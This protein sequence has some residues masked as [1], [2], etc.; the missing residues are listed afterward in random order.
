MV[1]SLHCANCGAP[2]SVKLGQTLAA[3]GYCN[4]TLRVAAAGDTTQ[5][6]VSRM[7]AVPPEVVD[8]VKRLLVL[9]NPY[10][11]V[12]YYAKETGLPQ[13]DANTAVEALRRTVG[14]A[15]ALN[16]LGIAMLVV[17]TGLGLA[18]A[19]FGVA[20]ATAGREALGIGLILVGLGWT[21]LNW[22]VL[23]R[24]LRAFWLTYRGTPAEAVIVKRWSIRTMKATGEPQPVE[25]VRFLLEVRPSGAT[26]YQTEANGMV[27][28]R[29]FERTQPGG[30]L[31]LRYDPANPAKVVLLGPVE[32]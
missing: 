2:L 8:E 11:A 21:L 31:K 19:A 30:R 18:A 22:L 14:Y 29:S 13:A 20:Q 3:C 7:M 10:K 27:R 6:P 26:P 5:P 17:F 28:Q 12:E 15:P 9:G 24:G 16:W 32:S 23:G 25:L 1:E 4:S